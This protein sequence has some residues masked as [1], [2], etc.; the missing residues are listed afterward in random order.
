[1]RQAAIVLALL[2]VLNYDAAAYPLYGSEETGIRRL[3]QARLAHEGI[4]DG[5]QKVT[6]ELL[7]V[8]F[9]EIDE[10]TIG[11]GVPGPVA[12][13]MLAKLQ[14]RLAESCGVALHS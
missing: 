3:E 6:G 10:K 2:L 8:I 1:M 9:G 11:Q 13:A 14:C 7:S 12:R 5:R 4:I